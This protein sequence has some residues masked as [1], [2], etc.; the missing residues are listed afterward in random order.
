M[1]IREL[2][3]PQDL[4]VLGPMISESFQY[5]ENPNWGVQEDERESLVNDVNNLARS[6]WMIKIGQ[7]FIPAMKDLLPGLVWEENN[8]IVGAVLLQRR[9]SSNH[10]VVGTVATR[11]KYRRKGIARKLVEAGLDLIRSRQGETAILDVIE[12]NFPAYKLYESLGFTHFTGDSNLEYS[13]QSVHP[14][15]KL[16][17]EYQLETTHLLD[18]TARYQLMKRIAPKS[19]QEFEPVQESLFRQPGYM[20]LVMPLIS[21]AQKIQH[22]LVLVHH[23]PSQQIAGYLR[24]DIRTGG[25]GRHIFSL[26]LDPAHAELSPQ[27]VELALHQITSVDPS[28]I[29]ET[30]LP[31]WLKE[32][33]D[34]AL[35]LGFKKRVLYHRLGL[36]LS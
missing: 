20:R 3:L 14:A 27:L 18:W 9:G 26:R 28:L 6:W 11:P 31:T 2:K 10:W 13:P 7:T 15:P 12:N 35:E 25:K 34:A 5:P 22:N 24:S 32:P 36:K 8:K 21:R 23:L 33:I 16:S 19:I 1:S 4:E 29:I 30:T 17:S